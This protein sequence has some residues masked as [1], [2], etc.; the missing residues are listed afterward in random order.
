M[1]RRFP[2]L[3]VCIQFSDAYVKDLSTIVFFNINFSFHVHHNY[4]ISNFVQQQ[5]LILQL[6]FIILRVVN[7]TPTYLMFRTISHT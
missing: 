7:L 1:F 3:F 2:S 4:K 5:I 6:F